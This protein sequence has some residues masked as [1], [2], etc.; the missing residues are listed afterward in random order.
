M[1]QKFENN[2]DI[3]AVAQNCVDVGVDENVNSERLIMEEFKPVECRYGGFWAIC[4][5][6]GRMMC[7]MR[8]LR[9]C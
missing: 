7:I 2:K 5:G 1:E 4:A 8:R 3:E 9:S 6:N